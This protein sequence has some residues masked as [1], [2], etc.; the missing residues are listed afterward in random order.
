MSIISPPLLPRT[1]ELLPD[2]EVST[3]GDP[4]V[5]STPGGPRR[6]AEDSG[7]VRPG[8]R[9]QIATLRQREHCRED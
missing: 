5:V 6:E 2:D 9:G 1:G 7:S 8:Q 3:S 4:A